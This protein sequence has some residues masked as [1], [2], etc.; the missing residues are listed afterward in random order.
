MSHISQTEMETR[1]VRFGDLR[2]CTTAFID[3]RTPGS[4]RK[5]NFT[6]IGRGVSESPDQHVHI[7]L[8]HGFNIGAARQPPGCVN[9]QHSHDT[10]EVFVVHAGTWRFK[11]GHDGTDGYV[12]LGPGDTISLPTRLF[13]GFENIGQDVGFMFAVLGQDNPGRV[14]W[15]PYVFEQA[16]RHGMVLLESGALVDTTI[17]SVPEGAV[18]MRPTTLEDTYEY[19]RYDSNALL[20]C[21]VRMQDLK[22]SGEFSQVAGTAESAVIGVANPA[23]GMPAAPIAWAHGFQLRNLQLEPGAQSPYLTRAES[24]VL[25]VHRGN[26]S[27]EWQDGRL[28]LAPGDTLS[29]PGGVERRYRNGGA[30]PAAMFVVRPGDHPAPIHWRT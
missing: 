29:L 23:E 15:A 22:P 25:L 13:R 8:P 30:M 4:E 18:R 19:T 27:I 6:I 28:T 14:T 7:T 1:L 26:P 21:V 17:T 9:S 16:E 12:D 24:E 20:R 11:S 2:P 3:T 5:E 10:A